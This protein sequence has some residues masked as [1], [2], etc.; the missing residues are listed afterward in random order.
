MR[1]RQSSCINER[2]PR[3]HDTIRFANV[4]SDIGQFLDKADQLHMTTLIIKI[5]NEVILIQKIQNIIH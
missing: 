4:L 3:I 1:P 2:N 5:I